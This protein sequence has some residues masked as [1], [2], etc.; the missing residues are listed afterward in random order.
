MSSIKFKGWRFY[1]NN[2]SCV[3]L[4]GGGAFVHTLWK[5]NICIM[6]PLWILSRKYQFPSTI[7]SFLALMRV[8]RYTTRTY[9]EVRKK[10]EIKTYHPPLGISFCET[11]AQPATRVEEGVNAF[12]TGTPFGGESFCGSPP[13]TFLLTESPV[14]KPQL[15][16]VSPEIRWVPLAT[17]T[18][19]FDGPSKTRQLM[20]IHAS[21]HPSSCRAAMKRRLKKTAGFG[22]GYR[23][24]NQ[25]RGKIT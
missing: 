23:G 21:E 19:S 16:V 12:A 4:H 1:H 11:T 20:E 6:N 22:G 5:I 9:G 17:P 24:K 15:P 10:T 13:P 8:A 25:S 14:L 18:P 3:I 7:K 2:S